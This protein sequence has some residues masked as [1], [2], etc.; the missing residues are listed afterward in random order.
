M[1][2][3]SATSWRPEG[4]AAVERMNTLDAGFYFVEHENV[5][6][7]IGS[8]VRRS[9]SVACG[10][11]RALRR[12]AVAGAAIPEAGADAAAAGV[13][14]VLVG[15]RALRPWLPP[16]ARRRPAA[17]RSGGAHGDGI[18]GLLA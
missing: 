12:E 6:M 4:S 3:W 18:A 8:L 16:A 13:P 7:H 1:M 9:G 10:P 5:P 2:R 15:R 11:A 17:G 14:P